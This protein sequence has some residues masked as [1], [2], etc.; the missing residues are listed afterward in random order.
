MPDKYDALKLD[1]QL[2]FPLY[3]A[4]KE[5][6]RRYTPYLNELDL[7]YTQYIAMMLMWEKK[8][9]LSR[10]MGK[11]LYLDSGTLT[12]VLKKLEEKGLIE[13]SRLKDDERNV[14]LT[15]TD[16]GEALRDRAIHVPERIR[17]CI[18]FE[19]Q[20]ALMLYQLL[21]KLLDGLDEA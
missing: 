19:P 3:A 13:R 5:I 18:R 17:M 20:E 4:S 9:I 6:V 8:S 12:P 14:L 15:L 10:D 2:C 1:H 7:T 21:Y 16:E 11:R